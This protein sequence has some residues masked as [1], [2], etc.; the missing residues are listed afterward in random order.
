M[1]TGKS[2]VRNHKPWARQIPRCGHRGADGAGVAGV[3]AG[4]EFPVAEGTGRR[5]MDGEGPACRNVPCS[6]CSRDPS[7]PPALA[8]DP[9]TSFNGFF[10]LFHLPP[11]A[12]SVSCVFPSS[13]AK[14]EWE[15]SW[16]TQGRGR[17]WHCSVPSPF[18]SRTSLPRG[19]SRHKRSRISSPAAVPR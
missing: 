8:W 9:P 17:W 10:F 6:V 12:S 7:A 18:G 15:T 11:T 5:M 16:R 13:E 4:G 3:A 2:G 14:G 19:L 1:A